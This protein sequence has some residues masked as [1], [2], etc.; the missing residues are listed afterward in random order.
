MTLVKP[1]EWR[2][3]GITDI[4]PAAWDALRETERS[5]CVTA[6]AGAGKTE[7]L[8]QKAAYLLQT[9]KCAAQKR[10]LAISFKRDAARNLR[11]RVDE[12][13][14]SAQSRRFDS[15]TFDSFTKHLLD[16]FSAAVPA[17]YTPPT[18]YRIIFPVA[19]DYNL[20]LQGRSAAISAQQLE[21]AIT[22]TPLPIAESQ[23]PEYHRDLLA[24]YWAY[25][26]AQSDDVLLSFPMINR[27]VEYMVRVN[28]QVRKALQITYPHVF[29]DEFQDTTFAQFSML[30]AVFA[31]SNAVFTAVGDDKQRIMGWA[32]A[33]PD[34]FNDFTQQFNARR[35]SLILNWRSHEALVA[36]QRLIAARIDPHVAPVEARGVQTVDGDV[37]AIWQFDTRE[38]E[39]ETLAA[40]VRR[41]I[42]TRLIEAHDVAIL[43]RMRADQ[44]EQELTPAFTANHLLLRNLARNVGSIA[45]Q[46]LLSE[47]FTAIILSLLRLGATKKHAQAWSDAQRSLR[48]IQAVVETDEIAQQRIQQTLEVFSRELRS[49]MAAITPHAEAVKE[50]IRRAIDFIGAGA[51]RQAYPEYDRDADFERVREGFELLMIESA[52]AGGTWLDALERFEGRGQVPLMT[53]HKSKGLEFHTM[54]FFG[55]DNRTWWSLAPNKPEELNSFFVAFTRAAQ[56][57]FFTSCTERGNRIGWIDNMLAPAGVGRVRGTEILD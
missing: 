25:Q 50:V 22:L 30:Q 43:V 45:I 11:L 6:G 7:F 1:A 14:A 42:D 52:E 37:A 15:M 57:A 34:A 13:C 54:V 18:D 48:Y 5:V 26:Y 56:R 29:L 44:V 47:E 16:R 38:E 49:H 23:M 41:Q 3:Q 55:L 46:E 27:L 53:L 8:A 36:I 31:G 19:D 2:P 32:G 35:V 17:P 10:I 40:W 51:V 33:M 24:S 39:C 4:E 12:R 21:K 9:G 28:P 20:F